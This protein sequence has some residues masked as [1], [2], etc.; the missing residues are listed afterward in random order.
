MKIPDKSVFEQQNV[1]G[2]GA[3]TLRMLV[4]LSEIPI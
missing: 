2:I 4:I 3:E 1:F